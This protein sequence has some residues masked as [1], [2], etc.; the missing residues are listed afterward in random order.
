MRK[1]WLVLAACT[2]GISSPAFAQQA[3]ILAAVNHF[4]DGFNK[5]DRKCC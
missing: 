4:V 3:E 1:T 2:L 5:G